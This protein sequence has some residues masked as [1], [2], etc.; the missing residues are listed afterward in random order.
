MHHLEQVNDGQD[1]GQSK[2]KAVERGRFSQF[3]QNDQDQGVQGV[4]DQQAQVLGY[5]EKVW[6]AGENA[7]K[8]HYYEH[9][10]L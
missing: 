4:G 5:V 8:F 7:H 9:F 1:S 6:V 3:E 2:E 10:D